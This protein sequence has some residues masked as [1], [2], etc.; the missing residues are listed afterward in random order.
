MGEW[1]AEDIESMERD[2]FDR[3]RGYDACWRNEPFREEA[4]EAW[5]TGWREA[6]SELST[7]EYAESTSQIDRTGQKA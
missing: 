7:D 5:K 4:S 1:E 3:V 6:D 2:L